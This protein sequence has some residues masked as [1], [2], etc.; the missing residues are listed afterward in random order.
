MGGALRIEDCVNADCPF[1][2]KPVW[3]DSLTCYRGR[4]VG[5][6]NPG[7]R[8]KFAAAPQRFPDALAHFGFEPEAG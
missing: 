5:F 7:C 4:V 2:G 3:D 8:D 1:S 6:C